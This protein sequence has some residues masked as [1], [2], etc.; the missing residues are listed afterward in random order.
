MLTAKQITAHF[1]AKGFKPS[2]LKS[3]SALGKQAFY[4]REE[5][6]YTPSMFTEDG[7]FALYTV[8]ATNMRDDKVILS[9][10]QLNAGM[11]GGWVAP[12]SRFSSD[13]SY[14]QR[15]YRAG[16]QVVL[17]PR[18]YVSTSGILKIED[19]YKPN[20]EEVAVIT[21]DIHTRFHGYDNNGVAFP[22]GIDFVK[23]FKVGSAVPAEMNRAVELTN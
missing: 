3:L 19:G 22:F 18:P 1:I 13:W 5:F 12:V 8:H 2:Q 11:T 14:P 16:H 10:Q 21:D 9:E 7:F 15:N 6:G 17:V 23:L 20:K 4:K